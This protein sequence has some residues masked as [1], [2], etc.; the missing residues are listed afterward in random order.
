MMDR[1]DRALVWALTV[2]PCLALLCVLGVA[3]AERSGTTLFAAEPAG[4]IAEAAAMGRADEV[5]RRLARGEDRFRVYDLRPE[6]ISSSVRKATLGEAAMWSRQ[7]L[8]IQLLDREGALGDART[9]GDLACLAIDLDVDE[10]IAA[11]LSPSGAPECVPQQ[12]RDRVLARTG[13][14]Q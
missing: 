9:R 6:V 8:M 10:G 12:A 1:H 2:P 14:P 5:V 13:V 4:N 3:V 7:L 11:L